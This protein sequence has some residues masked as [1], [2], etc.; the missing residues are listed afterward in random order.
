MSSYVLEAIRYRR[1]VDK[2]FYEILL[3]M[4]HAKDDVDHAI[5]F[6]SNKTNR[7]IYATKIYPPEPAQLSYKQSRFEK[8]ADP[9]IEYEITSK[10][11]QY[12]QMAI[13]W[14]EYMNRCGVIGKSLKDL[15]N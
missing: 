10:G 7:L 15:E 14:E 1:S 4:G 2:R 3:R 6:L 11:D 13:E 8:A 9:S 12:I 5:G